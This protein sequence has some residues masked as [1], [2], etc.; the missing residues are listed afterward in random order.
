MFVAPGVRAV[1]AV[2]DVLVPPDD[3]VP[4][5]VATGVEPAAGVHAGR[6]LPGHGRLL[7][8][9]VV[10]CGRHPAR[11]HLHRG[12]DPGDRVGQRGRHDLGD[13]GYQAAERT[14]PGG[15]LLGVGLLAPAGL[16]LDA[17]YRLAQLVLVQLLVAKIVDAPMRGDQA[18]GQL[19]AV[20][21]PAVTGIGLCA[22]HDDD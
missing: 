10:E 19:G 16:P 22:T 2:V 14:Q 15:D 18:A 6:S 11:G 5:Q 12:G 8:L 3:L 21:N 4:V 17:A 7:P 1:A 20:Y 13:V 9:C